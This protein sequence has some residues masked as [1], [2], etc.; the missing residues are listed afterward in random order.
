MHKSDWLRH[1]STVSIVVPFIIAIVRYRYLR[2]EYLLMICYLTVSFLTEMW[3]FVTFFRGSTN[4]LIVYNVFTL[5]ELTLL[6]LLY[7]QFINHRA[8]RRVIL[9]LIIVFAGIVFWR[10]LP[11]PSR[12]DGAVWGLENAIVI[13]FILLYFVHLFRKMEVERLSRSPIFWISSGLLIFFSG[14]VFVYLFG[15]FI[16]QDKQVLGDLWNINYWLNILFH[17]LVSI[18]FCLQDTTHLKTVPNT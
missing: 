3:G 11:D 16:F 6:G 10:Y 18:G 2:N 7:Y 13:L 12:Y 14:S 4:N 5:V 8:T 1:I 15:T 9:V 17:L